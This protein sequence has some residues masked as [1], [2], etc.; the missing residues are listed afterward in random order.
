MLASLIAQLVEFLHLHPHIAYTAVF[1]LAMS[2]SLPV[3]GALIPG[4]AAII[5]LSALVPSGVLVIWPLMGA[6]I[7]G[8]IAGDGFAFWLGHRFHR[9]ILSVWPFSRYPSS[10]RSSERFFEKYGLRSIFLARF[11]PGVRAFVPLL[12][13]TMM[14]PVIRF[15]TV[16]ILSAV[17][18]APA[19]ILPGVLFGASFHALG[20]AAKPAAALLFTLLVLGWLL[21][22]AIRLIVRKGVP[23]LRRAATHVQIRLAQKDDPVSR[24]VSQLF[25]PGSN[26]IRAI[27]ILC[28]AVVAFAWIFFGIAE[29]VFSRD[30]LV[31]VDLAVYNLLQ[32]F[33]S[34]PTDFAMVVV[35]ELGDT[36][37]VV[38]V[39][40]AILGYLVWKRAKHASIYFMAAV[41][42]ASLINTAIKVGMHRARPVDGLYDGLSAFS[43]PSGHSTVN[44]VLYGAIA[45]LIAWQAGRRFTIKAPAIAGILVLTIAFSRLYLGAHWFSDVVGGMAFGLAWLALLALALVRRPLEKLNPVILAAI[46]VLILA[47]A[48]AWHVNS[49]LGTD[50]QR[51]A[52]ALPHSRLDLAK[53]WQNGAIGHPR[54]RVDLSGE[55]REPF[56]VEWAG[57]LEDLQKALETSGWS[58][59]SPW[60]LQSVS[61]LLSGATPQAEVPPLPLIASG[62]FPTLSLVY[63]GETRDDRLVLRVWNSATEVTGRIRTPLWL[64]TITLETVNRPLGRLSYVSHDGDGTE[65]GLPK[66]AKAMQAIASGFAVGA[67]LLRAYTA[68]LD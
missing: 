48:G 22:H 11:I 52:A 63:P 18:W 43:F 55:M 35:T 19:H 60:G 27:G 62:S 29:D 37:V 5:T 54:M 59:A 16:N 30:P 10:I 66:V 40:V 34:A 6:A 51:Y 36:A 3:I 42:G 56:S 21:V 7:L 26:E 46:P 68:Q 20:P 9:Q 44:M 38:A 45:I 64:G 17:I 53:W 23:I 28:S 32:G 14:M 39:S 41:A 67:K 2:E 13:G 57:P 33:R 8:A 4:T 65:R 58:K 1:F 24:M 15:Y 50:L 47:S 49:R 25:D 61:A 31:N 12:A